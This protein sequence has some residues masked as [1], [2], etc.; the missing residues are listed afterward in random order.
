MKRPPPTCCHPKAPAPGWMDR[1]RKQAGRVTQ[2]RQRVL[3]A[4]ARLQRPSTPKEIAEAVTSGSCDLATVYRS[5]DLFESLGL[6]QRIDLGDGLARFEI[7]DDDAHGHHH[8]HLVCRRC[9][10]IVQ[11]DDCIL[12]D[13]EA[14]LA[15]HYGFTDI[16]HRLEFFGVCADCGAPAKSAAPKRASRRR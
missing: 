11:L 13:M 7:A 4:L 6:V 2:S 10:R 3:E 5:V 15:R 16:T 12:A 14:R 9:E 1:L 8:H